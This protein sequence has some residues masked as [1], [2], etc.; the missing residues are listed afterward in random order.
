MIEI[1]NLAMDIGHHIHYHD[2]VRC[3][4]QCLISLLNSKLTVFLKIEGGKIIDASY[5]G[6][7]CAF[8]NASASQVTEFVKGM[9]LKEVEAIDKPKLFELIGDNLSDN[10][11]RLSCIMFPL[12]TIKKACKKFLEHRS[13]NKQKTS[14]KDLDCHCDEHNAELGL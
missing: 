7:F 3:E 9:T 10:P 2:V 6:A 4:R 1:T 12:N 14:L 13:S 5:E 11:H 8:S